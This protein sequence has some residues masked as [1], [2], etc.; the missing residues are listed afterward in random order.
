VTKPVNRSTLLETIRDAVEPAPQAAASAAQTADNGAGGGT[1]IGSGQPIVVHIDQDLSD[2]VPGF[3]TRKREDGRA[4]LAAVERGDFEAIAR[5]GHKMKGEGGSYGLD[6]IT[7]L[8]RDLEQAGQDSDL[9]AARRLGGDLI[10]FLERVEIVYRPA[11][12]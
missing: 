7:D 12:D 10:N 6:A 4:I 2:L 11:E 1:A 9:D 8:G 3:L 5:L